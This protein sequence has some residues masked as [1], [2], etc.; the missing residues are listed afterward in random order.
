PPEAE[1]FCNFLFFFSFSL[2][3]CF[4]RAT[5]IPNCSMGNQTPSIIPKIPKQP[6]RDSSLYSPFRF[7]RHQ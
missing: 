2:V 1:A 3:L 4:C 7:K 6:L 5:T